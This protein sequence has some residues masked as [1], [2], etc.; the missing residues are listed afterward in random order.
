MIMQPSLRA[1]DV[2]FPIKI[3]QFY[4]T[5]Q[6]PSEKTQQF[7]SPPQKFSEA[8][9]KNVNSHKRKFR[10]TT[11]IDSSGK[12]FAGTLTSDA[13]I[14]KDGGGISHGK[15]SINFNVDGHDYTAT[16]I[17]WPSSSSTL[18]MIDDIPSKIYSSTMANSSYF[19]DANGFETWWTVC[20]G[21]LHIISCSLSGWGTIEVELVGA[22]GVLASTGYTKINRK[23]IEDNFESNKTYDSNNIGG[24]SISTVFYSSIYGYEANTETKLFDIHTGGA[25]GIGGGKINKTTFMY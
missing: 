4:S 9:K 2:H 12:V 22:I 21:G 24:V 5:N 3:K 8:V 7:H 1:E 16:D 20:G 18:V 25:A 13:L 23:F 19:N 15:V 14:L 6:A 10:E 17:E 11:L